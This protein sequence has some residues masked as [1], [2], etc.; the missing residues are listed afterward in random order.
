MSTLDIEDIYVA[1]NGHVAFLVAGDLVILRNGRAVSEDSLSDLDEVEDDWKTSPQI[2][3]AQRD[4]IA[5]LMAEEEAA[6]LDAANRKQERVASL[7]ARI[8]ESGESGLQYSNRRRSYT[9]RKDARG[10]WLEAFWGR[11]A[12]RVD[13]TE[14]D[15]ENIAF[16]NY[17]IKSRSAGRGRRC[18][19]SIA[20]VGE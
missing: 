7:I 15:I 8:D 2:N 14:E 1:T 12:Y 17:G 11:Y 3:A 4:A 6:I 18:D 16:N 13:L 19:I 5:R 10:Y 20:P 9:F